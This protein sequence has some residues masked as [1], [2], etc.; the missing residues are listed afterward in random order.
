MSGDPVFLAV[1][2]LLLTACVLA[3]VVLV[4][5]AVWWRLDDRRRARRGGD[6]PETLYRRIKP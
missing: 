5:D 2:G 6:L 4:V 1:L 3:I